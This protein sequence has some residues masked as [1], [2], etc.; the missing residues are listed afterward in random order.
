[1]K[2]RPETVP[3]DPRSTSEATGEQKS[4][5]NEKNERFWDAPGTSQE[6]PGDPG[7]PKNAKKT[8]CC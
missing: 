6:T 4:R 3:R 5:K 8:I 1:M 7:G 2:N